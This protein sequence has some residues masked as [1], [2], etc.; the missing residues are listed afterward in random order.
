VFKKGVQEQQFGGSVK[1]VKQG[2]ASV[3]HQFLSQLSTRVI[4]LGLEHVD[5]SNAVIS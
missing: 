2:A 5:M 3:R 4:H 1:Q